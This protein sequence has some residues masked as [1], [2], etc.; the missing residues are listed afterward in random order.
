MLL[1]DSYTKYQFVFQEKLEI[2]FSNAWWQWF[3]WR[4]TPVPI[5]QSDDATCCSLHKI[6]RGLRTIEGKK[7]DSSNTVRMFCALLNRLLSAVICA[8]RRIS[9]CCSLH[10]GPTLKVPTSRSHQKGKRFRSFRSN[11]WLNVATMISAR[12]AY[13]PEAIDYGLA[14]DGTLF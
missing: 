11:F 5:I 4:T 6:Q 7:C 1:L 2:K 13:Q 3:A 10:E 14:L 12:S 8:Q 9:M